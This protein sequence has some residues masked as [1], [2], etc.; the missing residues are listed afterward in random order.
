MWEKGTP[1]MMHQGDFC[2]FASISGVGQHLIHL[3]RK[4]FLGMLGL[5]T[6]L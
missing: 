5:I 3:E 1:A 4:Q 6:Y 2:K